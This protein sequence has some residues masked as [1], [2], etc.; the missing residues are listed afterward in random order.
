MLESPHTTTAVNQ[1]RPSTGLNVVVSQDWFAC[2]SSAPPR[3]AMADETPN[4]IS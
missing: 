2:V 4:T 1:K 3:P